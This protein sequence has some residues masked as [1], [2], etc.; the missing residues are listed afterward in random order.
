LGARFEQLHPRTIKRL[1]RDLTSFAQK[2]FRK[3]FIT[4]T[5]L[6]LNNRVA[7]SEQLARS[8]PGS[9]HLFKDYDEGAEKL[10]AYQTTWRSVASQN[11]SD[12]EQDKEEEPIED[13]LVPRTLTKA[14]TSY[15]NRR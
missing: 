10:E 6:E 11:D 2:V 8:L 14:K 1:K 9:E 3:F 12:S 7:P 4:S 15:T 13:C 5:N